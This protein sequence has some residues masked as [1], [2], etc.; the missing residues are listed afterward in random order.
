MLYPATPALIRE[1][2]PSQSREQRA[3]SPIVERTMPLARQRRT[4][5]GSAMRGSEQ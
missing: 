5:I 4:E 2:M 3:L 1:G